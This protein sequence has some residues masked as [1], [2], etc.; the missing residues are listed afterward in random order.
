MVIGAPGILQYARSQGF[1]TYENL[2]DETYDNVLDFDRKMEIVISNIENFEKVPYSTITLEK[3]R[4]NLD[5]F[6]NQAVVKQSMIE[7]IVMPIEKYI[8]QL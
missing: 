1:E 7:S 8:S 4:H 5:L 6:Y 2:F 3:I